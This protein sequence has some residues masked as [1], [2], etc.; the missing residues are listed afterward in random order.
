MSIPTAPNKL[1]QPRSLPPVTFAS[2]WSVSTCGRAP[3][4]RRR[5]AY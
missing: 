2:H 1:L 4:E 5:W 3:A